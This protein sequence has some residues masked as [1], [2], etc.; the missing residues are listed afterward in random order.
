[1]TWGDPNK[2]VWCVGGPKIVDWAAEPTW[3]EEAV[4]VTD[5]STKRGP[6]RRLVIHAAGY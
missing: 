5:N 3:C 4:E 6:E 1:M 2:G